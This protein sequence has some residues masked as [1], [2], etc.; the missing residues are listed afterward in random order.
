VLCAELPCS[1]ADAVWR[2]TDQELATLVL[3]CLQ[4][5]GLP[6]TFRVLEVATRRLAEAYPIYRP[7]FAQELAALEQQLDVFPGIVPL[8]RQGLFAHDNT[9]H[10]LAMAYAGAACI[11]DTGDFDRQRWA[12]ARQQFATF[13][14][15]D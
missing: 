7:G 8:G 13:V 11:Q 14:V 10:T 15:E 4:R 9:H 6:S 5:A 12:A 2:A 3:D 1:P